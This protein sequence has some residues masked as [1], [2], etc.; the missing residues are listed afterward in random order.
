LRLLF[1]IYSQLFHK[2]T[3]HPPLFET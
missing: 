2:T 1:F 3:V